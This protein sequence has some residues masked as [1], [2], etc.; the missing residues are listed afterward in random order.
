M[1]AEFR[2]QGRTGAIQTP[3]A[4][5]LGMAT[6]LLREAAFFRGTLGDPRA[7]REALATLYAVVVS[8]YKYRPKDRPAFFAWLAEQ[9]RKFLASLGHDPE[10]ISQAN[11]RLRELD[12]R[13]NTR[14][15]AFHQARERYIDYVYTNTFE[16]WMLLDPVI[17]IHPDQLQFEAFSKDESTYAAVSVDLNAFQRVHEFECGTTNVDFS[18]R[19]HHEFDRMRSY[20]Q[21]HFEVN[22]SGFTVLNDGENNVREK[23]IDLPDS[24]LMGFLQVHSTMDFQLTRLRL[25]PLDLINICRALRRRKAR[26]SPRALRYHLQPGQRAKV[27]L[28]PWDELIELSARYEGAREQVIRTWG[29]VRLL[30]LARLLPHAET[31]DVY[32]AGEGMPTIYHLGLPGVRLPLAL[33]GWTEMDWTG[34]SRFHL[35]ARRLELPQAAIQTVHDALAHRRGAT[36]FELARDTGLSEEQCRSGCSYLC[37]TGYA[38]RDLDADR[39]RFRNLLG[40][41][42]SIATANALVDQA[43]DA[44]NPAAK[45]ARAIFESDNVRITARR[46]VSDGYKVSGSAKGFDGRRVRP[47]IHVDPTGRILTAN[48]TC[49]T[50]K[51]QKLTLGGCAHILALRLGHMDLLNRD[52]TPV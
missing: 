13:R 24:W 43:A 45:E 10:A 40:A 25:D 33:S 41:P 1:K 49:S 36:S 8:D 17:S 4:T 12:E 19:L 11:E 38:M 27:Y 26:Q 31:L 34:Q 47:L 3:G 35:L 16:R 44:N 29:R 15:R 20:R 9:D 22:A 14:L 52:Q 48:C 28:E 18:T 7:L 6:N 32:L 46:K 30:T 39:Y 42:F 23:K 21:T 37:Q 50:Y 51:K 5:R 2:Y